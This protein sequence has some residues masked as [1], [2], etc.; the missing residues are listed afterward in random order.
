[1]DDATPTP[2]SAAAAEPFYAERRPDPCALVMFGI[3]G[4]LASRK[5]IPGLYNLAVSGYLPQIQPDLVLAQG[6]TTTVLATA[7]A[8]HYNR[9]AFAHV[10]AGPLVRSSYHARV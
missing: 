7:L 3:T 8:C 1:M 2:D 4:D 10:E 6:D 5:L 9:V